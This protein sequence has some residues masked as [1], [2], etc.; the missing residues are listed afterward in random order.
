MSDKVFIDTNI[1]I[2]LYAYDRD[3][4]EKLW[5]R[6]FNQPLKRY[7]IAKRPSMNL[8]LVGRP[9]F[10]LSAQEP[11]RFPHKTLRVPY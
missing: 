2:L 7:F 10:L 8:K 9:A 6:W 3:A 11:F 4:G 5:R 1:L